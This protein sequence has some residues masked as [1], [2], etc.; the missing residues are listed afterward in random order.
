M[1]KQLDDIKK[2]VTR[3]I[4]QEF[5]KKFDGNKTHFAKKAG[6]D[7]KTIRLLFDFGQGMTLNLL[8]KLAFALDLNPSDIIKDLS[9]KKED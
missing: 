1:Q 7:E 3:R 9:I 5:L 4:H 6:C 8:F 2:E